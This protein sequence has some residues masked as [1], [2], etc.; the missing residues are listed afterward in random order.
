MKPA[1]TVAM[2]PRSAHWRENP[3]LDLL[4]Q[5]LQQHN[6]NCV[7]D[8]S[9][10]LSWR[11]L[12][13]Q[14]GR[15]QVLHFHWLEY[16]YERATSL[17]SASALTLFLLK[18]ML[19]RALGY[20][21][22]WTVHNIQPHEPKHAQLDRMCWW[23]L[24]YLAQAIV[25]HCHDSARQVAQRWGAAAAGKTHVIA[26]PNY[27]GVYKIDCDRHTARQRLNLNDDHRVLLYLGAVRPYKGIEDA[28]A[29]F[30]QLS[31]PQARLILAGR[32]IND[33]IK[34]QI[35]AL[36][37]AD[38][39]IQA[40]FEYIPAGE[41]AHY[42]AAADAVVLPFRHVQTSGSALL[43]MSLAR[44]VLTSAQGCLPELIA[45]ETGLLYEPDQPGALAAAMQHIL[46]KDLH[47]MGERAQAHVSAF[48][49][50]QVGEGHA[51]IYVGS[52]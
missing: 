10:G 3:Y 19:A 43:A 41:I 9:D 11:W 17:K 35:A 38:A 4:E 24:A 15:V 16:H 51:K 40:I 27:I 14:R 20:R 47:Q 8:D 37:A 49:P 1:L 21:L 46:Q 30:R 6:V 28:I 42:Y 13:A 44:P 48:T 23:A 52:S 22:V 25:V 32:P 36:A 26:H 31:D 34:A 18:L 29:A 12:W 5:G 7:R 33:E 50:A 45:P 2:F 39:R